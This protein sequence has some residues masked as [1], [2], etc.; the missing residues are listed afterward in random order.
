VTAV[1]MLAAA[2]EYADRGWPVFPLHTPQADGSCSCRKDCGKQCGKHP[3]TAHGLLDATID[4]EQIRKWW[5][6][7]PDANLAVRTG[8]ACDM[9]DID[10]D[11]MHD[12]TADLPAFDMPGGP[13]VRTGNGWHFYLLP[14]REG[15]RTRFSAHCDWRGDGG[16]SILPPSLHFTGRRYEWFV[17]FDTRLNAAPSELVS[18]LQRT[19]P[20]APARPTGSPQTAAVVGDAFT[21]ARRTYMGRFKPDKLVDQVRVAPEGKRNSVLNWAAVAAGFAV[22]NRRC[23][24]AEG[25][26][27]L[28]RIE[29]AAVAA[30]LTPLEAGKTADSGYAAGLSG[31]DPS[32]K[33]PKADA[34]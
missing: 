15:N 25:R 6:R 10:H 11:D 26:D 5:T 24:E 27:A 33:K 22:Y 31:R 32:T 2:L 18:A 7:W 29:D 17:P 3:R 20:R 1:D 9:F 34:A 8:V 13:I 14:T 4:H 16:Y 19:A 23:T 28:R 30:G 12:G 21:L